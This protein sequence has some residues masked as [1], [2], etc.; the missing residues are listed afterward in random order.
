[1]RVIFLTH[2]FPPEVG[3]PQARMFELARRL[4]AEGDSVTVVTGFPNYPTGIVHD[5]Y[6]GR[7]AME[8]DMD[9]VR[10]IRRWV[11]ATPNAGFAKRIVNHL[12][13]A[14][15][16]LTAVRAAG[17][18]GV[19]WVESPPLPIGIA[20]IAYAGLKRAPF[21]LNVSDVWPQSA[22]ELGALRNPLAI[23]AAEMLERVLY[24]RAARITVPT[25]GILEGLAE[26][27]VPRRKLVHLTNG[28]DVDLYRPE[29][30]P[31]GR[32]IFMYA[33]THGLSQGLDVVLEAARLIRDP[34]VEFVLVG[35]GA[36]KAA[37]VAKAASERITNVRFLP[38]QPRDRMPALL[39]QAY[40]T[41]ITLKALDVFR[42]ARPSK[43]YESMAVGR[44]IVASLWGEAAEMVALAGCGVV[45]PPED[46]VALAAAI[47]QLAADPERARSMGER[48]RAYAVEHF[49][50]ASI[51]RRL[52]EVLHEAAA[53][54]SRRGA[55]LERAI[56]VALSLPALVAASPLMAAAAVAIKLDSRGPVFYH[57]MRAGRDGVPFRIHKLR[58]MRAGAGGPSVTAG[59]D[60]R[61]TRVGRVLRRTKLDELPQLL[62]VVKGDMSLVGPRPEHPDYVAHYTPRQRRLLS[63]RPGLTGPATLAYL[64]EEEQLRGGG[65]ET[66]YLE[67]VLPLKLELELDYLERAT[68]RSRAAILLRT[69]GAVLRRPCA[70]AR[71]SRARSRSLPG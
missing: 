49:S 1:M 55:R 41:V 7:L 38:N 66:N 32:K 17:P 8:E 26:R 54:R 35:E 29:P 64:D 25:P 51:A 48:G 43:M 24:R 50:R 6:R 31:A 11:Y 30:W 62:N 27:G 69:A 70:P 42:R 60:P 40:A 4:V 13:F 53:T 65:A 34:E 36:D 5:G 37:L 59:D 39:N 45:V 19:L 56:D 20:A 71:R 52:R 33:G 46:P 15:S 28:V 14:A 63:V 22:V 10:T 57:G 21:V 12:S 2:Y 23:R 47:E 3:A 16:S 44:P 18:A 61:I 67:H 58:T 68:A 9:G